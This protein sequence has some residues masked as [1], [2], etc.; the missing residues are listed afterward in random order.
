ME[1]AHIQIGNSTSRPVESENMSLFG[2]RKFNA[3]QNLDILRFYGN[4]NN[5]SNCLLIEFKYDFSAQSN[6]IARTCHE[7]SLKVFVLIEF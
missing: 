1:L 7:I 2:T 4:I 3:H 6:I 5:F